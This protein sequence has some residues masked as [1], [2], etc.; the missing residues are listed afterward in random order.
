[1]MKIQAEQNRRGGFA[2][3]AMREECTARARSERD[4]KVCDIWGSQRVKTQCEY[5][6]FHLILYNNMVTDKD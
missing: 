5:K 3:M 2:S 4:V 6:I 1:M